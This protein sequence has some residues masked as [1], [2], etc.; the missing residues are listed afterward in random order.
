MPNRR[1]ARHFSSPA[2]IAYQPEAHFVRHFQIGLGTEAHGNYCS[3][4]R[5]TPKEKDVGK[6]GCRDHRDVPERTA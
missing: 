6:F 2:A 4:A 5:T 1:E 3:I